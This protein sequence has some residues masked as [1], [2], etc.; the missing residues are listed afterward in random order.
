MTI[1][2]MTYKGIIMLVLDE[3]GVDI[4]LDG[5]GMAFIAVDKEGIKVAGPNGSLKVIVYDV[6][7]KCLVDKEDDGE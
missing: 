6:L 1:N 7:S 5:T 4:T 3:V 2:E